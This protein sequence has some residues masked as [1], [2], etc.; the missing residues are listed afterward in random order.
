ME[1]PSEIS[2]PNPEDI[3]STLN[4]M[5]INLSLNLGEIKKVEDM[6]DK[7][8][9]G[10]LE[11]VRRLN[12]FFIKDV[13]NFKLQYEKILEKVSKKSESL[14]EKLKKDKEEATNFSINEEVNLNALLA[15]DHPKLN[16]YLNRSLKIVVSLMICLTPRS[17][18]I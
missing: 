8:S 1:R 12:S 7:S 16:E 5:K 11:P 14:E 15:N 17:L 2:S 9:K 3:R 10:I 18:M 6:L 4:N 13:K